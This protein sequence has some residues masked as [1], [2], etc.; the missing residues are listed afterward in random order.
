MKG[1]LLVLRLRV[2][3]DN[4]EREDQLGALTAPLLP[5]FMRRNASVRSDVRTWLMTMRRQGMLSLRSARIRRAL[6]SAAIT[7]GMVAMMNSV[8]FGS[9]KSSDTCAQGAPRGER[10]AAR[11]AGGG[12]PVY[13]GTALPS[14]LCL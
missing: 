7:V 12:T 3:T 1:P 13:K 14:G 5:T 11:K 10:R 6:S 9:R 4:H 8:C 2:R